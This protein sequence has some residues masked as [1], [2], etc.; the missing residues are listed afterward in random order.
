MVVLLL[1]AA[2]K[3]RGTPAVF[4]IC[5]LFCGVGKTVDSPNTD[6]TVSFEGCREGI[7]DR[8]VSGSKELGPFA[9]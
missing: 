8:R 6:R 5:W 9:V 4:G 7:R 3:R 2:G 1:S